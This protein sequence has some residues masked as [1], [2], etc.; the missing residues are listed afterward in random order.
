[1]QPVTFRPRPRGTIDEAGDWPQWRPAAEELRQLESFSDGISAARRADVIVEQ[2]LRTLGYGA[3]ANHWR[4][5][6]G[7]AR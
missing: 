2:F 1:M 7:R 3:I 6:R 4:A 5:V